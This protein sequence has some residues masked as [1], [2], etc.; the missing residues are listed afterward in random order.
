MLYG[1][2]K[3]NIKEKDIKDCIGYIIEDKEI[4]RIVGENDKNN[5]V[6]TLTADSDNNYLMVYYIVSEI[7]NQPSFWR[8]IDTKGKNIGTPIYIDEPDGVF[9]K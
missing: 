6:Y 1:T 2:L 8:A 9:W 7:M 3:G 5:R 4:Q